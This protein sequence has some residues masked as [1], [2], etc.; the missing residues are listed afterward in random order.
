MTPSIQSHLLTLLILIIILITLITLS[1]AMSWP[2]LLAERLRP[3]YL[4]RDCSVCARLQEL[5]TGITE[6]HYYDPANAKNYADP[7]TL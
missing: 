4:A 2:V 3:D 6:R 7:Y 1:E 5:G